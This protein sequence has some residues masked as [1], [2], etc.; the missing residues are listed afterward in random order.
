MNNGLRKASSIP[1]AATS[2][3][4]SLPISGPSIGSNLCDIVSSQRDALFDRKIGLATEGLQPFLVSRL[5][6]LPQ[7]N[8]LTL[9]DY[10]ISMKNEINL[11]DNYRKLNIYT[12][13]SLSFLIIKR[14]TKSSQEKTY[15]S[16]LIVSEDRKHQTLYINGSEVIM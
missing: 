1:T 8:A 11:S 7:E 3:T 15:C 13:Y 14:R 12:L 16:I 6:R 4:A 2:T 5:K 9:V 10:I